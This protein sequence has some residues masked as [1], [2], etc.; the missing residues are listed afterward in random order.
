MYKGNFKFKKQQ[1]EILIIFTYFYVNIGEYIIIYFLYLYIIFL[2][3][4][5]NINE[6]TIINL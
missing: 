1:K 5:F 2:T 6:Q 3:K 4:F